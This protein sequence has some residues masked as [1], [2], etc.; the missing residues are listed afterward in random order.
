MVHFVD[1]YIFAEKP[2]KKAR[3]KSNKI[4]YLIVVI[5][6]CFISFTYNFIGSN[7]ILGNSKIK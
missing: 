5:P 3:K 4:Q 7:N 6:N 1:Y 2:G